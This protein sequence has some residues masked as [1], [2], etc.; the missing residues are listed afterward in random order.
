M[1]SQPKDVI[2]THTFSLE[3]GSPSVLGAA[4]FK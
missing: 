1:K 3:S 2:G 4:N